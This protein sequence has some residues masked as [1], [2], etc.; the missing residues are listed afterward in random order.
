MKG[1]T[2]KP[3]LKT[4]FWARITNSMLLSR[5]FSLEVE[6]EVNVCIMLLERIGAQEGFELEVLTST[7]YHFQLFRLDLKPRLQR[8]TAFIQGEIQTEPNMGI[9]IITGSVYPAE[10]VAYLSL[11][12]AA[13]LFVVFCLLAGSYSMI[14]GA[15]CG[16]IF[17]FGLGLAGGLLIHERDALLEEF[18]KQ[19]VSGF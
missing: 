9:S 2:N 4:P 18:R 15:A 12:L 13:L 3:K 10:S 17:I 16:S 8:Y 6:G 1:N 14:V 7:P 5:P 11:C 19:V